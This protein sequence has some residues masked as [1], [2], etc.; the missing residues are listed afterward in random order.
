MSQSWGKKL[1]YD[2]RFDTDDIAHKLVDMLEALLVAFAAL[3]IA[4]NTS[5]D[6]LNDMRDLSTGYAWGF[7]VCLA[8]N[9][10]LHLCRYLEI[11]WVGDIEPG[12]ENFVMKY[13]WEQAGSMAIFLAA[14]V[15]SNSGWIPKYISNADFAAALWFGASL[16]DS[17]FKGT[18]MLAFPLEKSQ[19]V[20]MHMN[21]SLHRIG[22]FT[23][24]MIG[25]SVLSLI[26]GGYFEAVPTFYVVF[27][28]GFVS[29]TMIQF[30]YYTTQPFDP[31]RHCMRSNMVKGMLWTNCQQ[32]LSIS[33]VAF[34]VSLKL[35]AKYHHHNDFPNEYAWFGS[36]SLSL[37][38]FL[39]MVMASLHQYQEWSLSS[40]FDLPFRLSPA[41][42]FG[43]FL[44]LVKFSVFAGILGLPLAH[45]GPKMF[46]GLTAF[47]LVI[48]AVMES[49]EDRGGSTHSHDTT[50]QGSVQLSSHGTSNFKASAPAESRERLSEAA[51]AQVAQLARPVSA[52]GI[53]TEANAV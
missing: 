40:L 47:F 24:L 53:S 27:T 37:C 41:N 11:A 39:V 19:R 3:H 46:S 4:G 26:V 7:S 29:S 31:D 45:P 21:F 51:C 25:E 6:Q 2:S 35:I 16:F 43:T 50:E 5:H 30:L 32:V 20:P 1:Q 36:G 48:F 44:G 52:S 49:M 13:V 12:T 8:A 17:F 38:I 14:A 42:R 33:L 15:F 23:M 18:L 22:E 34:G 10:S 28:T 9:R